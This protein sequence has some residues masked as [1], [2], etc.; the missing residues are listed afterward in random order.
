MVRI[1]CLCLLFATT[2]AFAD[3]T[4][5]PPVGQAVE[6][7]FVEAV[8]GTSSGQKVDAVT[9]RGAKPTVYAFIPTD[10]W[11]R[12]SAR[13]LK[14]LDSEVG[15]LSDVQVVAVWLTPDVN[16]SKE[17]LPKAQQSLQFSRTDLTV[18]AGDA[19][20]PGTWGINTDADVTVVVVKDGK[21]G[22]TFGFVSVND[23]VV[24]QVIT[25]LK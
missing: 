11:S 5:G 18:F 25:A 22:Q 14:K 3:V 21:V 8:T 9:T 16:A 15:S 13:F 10:K 2:T 4:S 24:D 6:G 23:T 20:G 17:Y 1:W 19:S 7:F 12:P